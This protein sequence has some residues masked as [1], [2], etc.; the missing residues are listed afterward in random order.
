MLVG[1]AR[2]STEGQ[3]LNRQIDMLIDYGVDKRNI[4][5]EKVSGTRSHR[6]QLDKMLDE[7][8]EGDSVII[9]DLTRISR[10]TKD[11][12]NILDRIKVKGASIKSIK[13]TW[14]DTSSDNPYNSFL[15]TVMSGLSQLERDLISQRTKEGLKS[16]K[17]RGRNGGRPSKRNNK[18]DTVGLLYREGYKIVDIVKQTGLSRAT[19]YRVL[20]DLRLKE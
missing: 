15:L 6:E 7:L 19:I 9:T 18:A 16:A 11:L 4:Y 1:Y 3:S 8:Q 17:V 20:N 13:D 10:S 14:L 2:V 5:Q 12:L